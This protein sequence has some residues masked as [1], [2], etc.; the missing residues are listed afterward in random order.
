M[1]M[2]FIADLKTIIDWI[3]FTGLNKHLASFAQNNAV[4][5]APAGF[6][7]WKYA[8]FRASLTPDKWDD[9]AIQGLAERLGLVKPE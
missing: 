3:C 4:W 5:L 8:A 2:E 1:L 9:E 7:L 6:F